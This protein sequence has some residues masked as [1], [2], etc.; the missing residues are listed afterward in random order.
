MGWLLQQRGEAVKGGHGSHRSSGS[1]NVATECVKRISHIAAT[2]VPVACMPSVDCFTRN[3]LWCLLHKGGLQRLEAILSTHT[4]ACLFW[5]SSCQKLAILL[6]KQVTL[7]SFSPSRGPHQ[8][9]SQH[10][11]AHTSPREAN[12]EDSFLAVADQTMSTIA[13]GTFFDLLSQGGATIICLCCA[14]WSPACCR[15]CC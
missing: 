1:S 14:P 6:L 5:P 11:R 8:P 2:R 10:S 13:L 12:E 4:H 15:D 3:N 9:H 7:V